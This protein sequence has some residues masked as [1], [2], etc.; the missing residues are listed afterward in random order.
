MYSMTQDLLGSQRIGRLIDVQRKVASRVDLEDS[1]STEYVAG[2]DQA[3]LDDLIIS[4]K[5]YVRYVRKARA[6]DLAP[7]RSCVERCVIRSL[8]QAHCGRG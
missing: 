4:R 7:V 5:T 3:F 8:G 2:V 1:F 6:I